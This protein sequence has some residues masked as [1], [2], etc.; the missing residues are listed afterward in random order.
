MRVRAAPGAPLYNKIM[1]KIAPSLIQ[2]CRTLRRKGLSLNYIIRV[3]HLPKSTIYDNIRDINLSLETKNRLHQSSIRPLVEFSRKRKGKCI[4]GR[5]VP[6]PKGW[7][8]DLIYL[9]AH[10]M[11]DGE[12]TAHSCIYSNR[13]KI[14]INKV[15]TLMKKV[16]N[17]EPYE[18]LNK[19]TGVYRISYHYVELAIYVYKRS[20]EL[21]KYIK[22]AKEKEKIVFLKAFFDDEGCAYYWGNARKV[23]GYQKNIKVL[24]LVRKLLKDFNIESRI[25]AKYKEI[26]I[27]RRENLIR[28]QD[29][30]NFSRGVFINP[31]RKN[32]IWK[33]K[34]EKREILNRMIGSYQK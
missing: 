10:F 17:L 27:S 16:F 34:I 21:L 6:K 14:L 8:C 13:N 3:V 25:D 26:V 5:V 28:F 29:V 12:I 32:S 15:R 2:K 11:F 7:F 4:P 31:G 9:V 22:K 23:R 20:K 24:K 19:N 1:R 33:K 18:Y 30:I